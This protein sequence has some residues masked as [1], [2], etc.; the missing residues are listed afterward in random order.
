MKKLLLIASFYVCSFAVVNAQTTRKEVSTGKK[1]NTPAINADPSKQALKPV[2]P[3][4]NQSPT[5]APATQKTEKP[6]PKPAENST[7]KEDNKAQT[8]PSKTT[9]KKDGTPD[10]RYKANQQKMK[11]DGTPDMRY[12]ENKEVPKT[13]K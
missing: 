13:K 2:S 12:K 3:R 9:L 4:V 1:E 10:K 11:K 5:T 6:A 8:A 7:V